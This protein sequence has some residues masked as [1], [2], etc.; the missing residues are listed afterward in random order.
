V[1]FGPEHASAMAQSVAEPGEQ[2]IT[3]K[4]S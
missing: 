4:A 2:R 3:A 1:V